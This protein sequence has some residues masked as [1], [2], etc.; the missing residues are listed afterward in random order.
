ML[1]F[2]FC[3]CNVLLLLLL[4]LQVAALVAVVVAIINNNWPSRRRRRRSFRRH[5]NFKFD[6]NLIFIATFCC[7]AKGGKRRKAKSKKPNEMRSLR[8]KGGIPRDR[9][10]LP[11]IAAPQKWP[12]QMEITRHLPPRLEGKKEDFCRD[13]GRKEVG[14][15]RSQGH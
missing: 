1:F 15:W 6:F 4:L 13:L 14:T 10:R 11:V 12:F 8:A 2:A 9:F 5:L 7:G 3:N